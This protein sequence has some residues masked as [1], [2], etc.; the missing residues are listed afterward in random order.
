V[1][2]EHDLGKVSDA[3]LA[4]LEQDYRSRAREVLRELEEQLAP[5]R[6]R[7]QRLLEQAL[8]KPVPP[9][10]A[11]AVTAVEPAASANAAATET[12]AGRCAQCG[13]ANDN[14]AVFC[15]KCGARVRS[16]VTE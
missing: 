14:D 8:G 15:K 10:A 3:D 16:E 1:R 2:L 5:H 6:P 11:P 7:A 12:A 13:L 4:R 9:N